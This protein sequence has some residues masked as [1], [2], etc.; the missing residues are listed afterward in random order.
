MDQRSE[1]DEADQAD[2][3]DVS[4]YVYVVKLREHI[5]MASPVYKIGRSKSVTQRMCDYP[6]GSALLLTCQ[7]S[8]MM[9][10][11]RLII[12]R[13]IGSQY[14][15]MDLGNEYFEGN[16][17]EIMQTVTQS[18]VDSGVHECAR[19]WR[20]MRRGREASAIT[21]QT[22]QTCE[23][24]MAEF[25][26][27]VGGML[28]GQYAGSILKLGVVHQHVKQFAEREGILCKTLTAANV[29]SKLSSLYGCKQKKR[30][31]DIYVH[32][33]GA[34]GVDVPIGENLNVSAPSLSTMTYLAEEDNSVEAFLAEHCEFGEGLRESSASLYKEESSGLALPCLRPLHHPGVEW[35]YPR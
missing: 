31:G 24:V 19:A 29:G 16:L 25:V 9:S 8:D 21:C 33:P 27:S 1:A 23:Y 5:N 34:E 32:F 28:S 26:K 22:G 17:G 35:Q 18:A 13:L 7:T 20:H 15:R 4:G 14:R 3:P 10:C 2:Q 6:A 11:E 30:N 12:Q